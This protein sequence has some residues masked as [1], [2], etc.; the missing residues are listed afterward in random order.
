MFLWRLMGRFWMFHSDA[1]AVGLVLDVVWSGLD[2]IEADV[3]ITYPYL[4]RRSIYFIRLNRSVFIVF[5]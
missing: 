3:S 4:F 1:R 5:Y 2:I